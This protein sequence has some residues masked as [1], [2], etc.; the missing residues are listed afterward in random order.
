VW[1][2][3]SLLVRHGRLRWFGHVER[4]NKSDWVSACRKLEVEG[5]R[6]K[7]RGRTTWDECVRDDINGLGLRKEDAQDR[8]RWKGVTYGNRPTLPKCGNE[9]VS[10]YGLRPRDVKR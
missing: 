5:V 4:K 6:G 7:G 9:D 3:L 10:C 8:V 2:R 1:Q